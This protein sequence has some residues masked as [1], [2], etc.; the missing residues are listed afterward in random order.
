MKRGLAFVFVAVALAAGAC[1]S[2]VRAD[3]WDDLAAHGSATVTTTDS[4]G[5]VGRSDD[6][7][8]TGTGTGTTLRSGGD[9]GR[10]SGSGHATHATI[11]GP[12]PAPADGTYT[13]DESDADGR[14][15][16]TEK[17]SAQRGS[18]AV[19]LTS[20]VTEQQDG[21]TV[22]TTTKYRVTRNALEMLSDSSTYNDEDAE[23]CTYK[24]AVLMLQLPLQTGDKW[25][26]TGNC[27]EDGA[28]DNAASDEDLRVEV[29]GPANDTIGGTAVK[30]FLVRS[31]QSFDSTDATSGK[32]T[33]FTLTDTRHVDPATLLVVVE[34]VKFDFDG[35]ASNLHRQL[36]SLTP[37]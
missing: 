30:T 27:S 7:G 15:T 23:T 33:T 1:G 19:A 32:R 25:E 28:G 6:G 5:G 16:T 24:P 9:S 34:D 17:W 35:D 31:T 21:D 18:D 14:R 8:R 29:T 10:S 3:V 13:Y 4:S 2:R 36:R 37:A 12:L 20:V 26:S 22:T 11:A